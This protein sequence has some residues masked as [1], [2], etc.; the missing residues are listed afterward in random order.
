MLERT[1]VGLG[2]AESRP[3]GRVAT[4][5]RGQVGLGFEESRPG[6]RVATEWRK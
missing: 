5:W 6:G 3:G 1:Q 2:F 4:E